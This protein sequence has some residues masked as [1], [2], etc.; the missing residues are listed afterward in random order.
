MNMIKN[1]NTSNMIKIYSY[2]NGKKLSRFPNKL[3]WDVNFYLSK[4]FLLYEY[5]ITDKN[6]ERNDYNISI[7][8]IFRK[9]IYFQPLDPSYISL[10]DFDINEIKKEHEKY[11]KE[12]NDFDTFF[13]YYTMQQMDDLNYICVTDLTNYIKSVSDVF[14]NKLVMS[15]KKINTVMCEKADISVHVGDMCYMLIQTGE[16]KIIEDLLKIL[17][18]YSEKIVIEVYKCGKKDVV[19]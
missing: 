5:Y 11:E 17:R 14:K 1:Y 4:N 13:D 18:T 7:G 3:I 19:T 10:G 8:N 9:N 6:F 15:T 16:E 12:I 2:Q